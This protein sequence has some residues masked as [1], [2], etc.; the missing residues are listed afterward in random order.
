MAG[1]LPSI[2]IVTME[3]CRSIIRQALT[4]AYM[5]SRL[6]VVQDISTTDRLGELDVSQFLRGQLDFLSLSSPSTPSTPPCYYSHI[7][8]VR[9]CM[10]GVI[11]MRSQLKNTEARR[12]SPIFK[13]NIL[14]Y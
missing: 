10:W 3:I 4:V 6:Y 7:C 12:N 5:H 14:L 13:I 9:S 11:R 8:V 2:Q 1:L